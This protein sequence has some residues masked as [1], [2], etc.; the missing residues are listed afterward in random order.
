MLQH[1]M[2]II[3]PFSARPCESPTLQSLVQQPESRVLEVQD[4]DA[5]AGAIAEDEEMSIRRVF[6]EDL[7][8]E[9][10]QTIDGL[11][12]VGWPTAKVDPNRRRETQHDLSTTDRRRSRSW[13]SNPQGIRRRQESGSCKTSS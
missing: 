3:F 4:L 6:Q 13:A 2:A 12:H 8:S 10:A 5:I 11:A 1:Q 7:P 9:S